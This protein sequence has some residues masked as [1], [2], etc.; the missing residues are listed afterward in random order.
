MFKFSSQWQLF[1]SKLKEIVQVKEFVFNDETFA[2][3]KY[4]FQEPGYVL[5]F[6]RDP[7]VFEILDEVYRDPKR[8]S[9]GIK[10]FIDKNPVFHSKIARPI[11]PS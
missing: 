2:E 8:E 3:T 4:L 11:N 9:R 1:L 7:G 6:G 10:R 5:L